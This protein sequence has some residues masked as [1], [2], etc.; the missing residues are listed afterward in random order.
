MFRGFLPGKRH[1]AQIAS[2]D[3]GSI[4]LFV[5]CVA[6]TEALLMA[7]NTVIVDVFWASID[8][9]LIC[10]LSYAA[11]ECLAAFALLLGVRAASCLV[12]T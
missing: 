2:C 9:F 8:T 7:S 12:F 11:P 3:L 1:A 6:R 5:V 10:L 4:S